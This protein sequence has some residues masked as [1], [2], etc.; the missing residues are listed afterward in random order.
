MER[1]T[2]FSPNQLIRLVRRTSPIFS[3]YQQHDAEEFLKFLIDRLDQELVLSAI[4]PEAEDEEGEQEAEGGGGGVKGGAKR[5]GRSAAS[6][7]HAHPSEASGI[8]MHPAEAEHS[9]VECSGEAAMA[10]DSAAATAAGHNGGR[11]S[12][13]SHTGEATRKRAPYSAIRDLFGGKTATVV[14][15]T[16]CSST[17][18]REEDCEGLQLALSKPFQEEAEGEPDGG[19][20]ENLVESL[21]SGSLWFARQVLP[22]ETLLGPLFPD[23]V[24][25]EQEH[26]VLEECLENFF[27]EERM[28]DDNQYVFLAICR[29]V[30]CHFLIAAQL[31]ALSIPIVSLCSWRCMDCLAVDTGATRC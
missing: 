17:S 20:Q 28:V 25:G 31:L 8:A 14:Q 24:Y 16:R 21:V 11:R 12:P 13:P 29:A 15:C 10:E 6:N 7:G 2:W 5:R 1:T 22:I 26:L 4:E 9:E 23:L 27:A 19:G 18:I 30:S 3:G